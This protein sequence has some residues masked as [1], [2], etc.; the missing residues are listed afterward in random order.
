MKFRS[1]FRS[2]RYRASFLIAWLALSIF[3]LHMVISSEV[4]KAE[5]KFAH[6]VHELSTDI[7]QK[8]LANDAVLSGFSA[9]LQAVDESDQEATARYAAAA[10]APYPH[11]YML[12]VARQLPFSEQSSL[13][14]S[15][16]KNGQVNFSIRS[17]AAVSDQAII[18]EAPSTT[19][20]PILFIYPVIPVAPKI[21]G[22][23][24]ETVPFL[25]ESLRLI[26]HAGRAVASPIF[27]LSEGGGEAF[28]LLRQAER[29]S[30]TI[31]PGAPN[32]FGSSMAALL[33]S[34]STSLLP[35]DIGR[36]NI[37][38]HAE[39]L[40]EASTKAST[41][42]QQQTPTAHWLDNQTLPRFSQVIEPGISS[43]PVRLTFERQLSWAQLLGPAA[44]ATVGMLLA[45]IILVA[46]NIRRYHQA[47]DQAAAEHERAEHLAMHDELT[48]LPNR[49]LLNDRF[50][51][52]LH[53]WE[54]HGT[55]F[56]LFVIDLDH[57]KIIN[58]TQG[59]EAGDSVLVAT[60][61][62]ISQAIRAS[63]TV[64]RFGGDEFIVLIADVLNQ[65]D[66]LGLGQKL[67][68]L[69]NAPITWRN[70]AIQPTCSLGI[71][72]CPDDGENFNVL[73]QQADRA[74]YQVKEQGRNGAQLAI[75]L[76]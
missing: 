10:L 57:F 40:S 74:M 23:R 60:A 29:A 51:Q 11:I 73:F 26:Q 67:C 14:S 34:K 43:Q 63:D 56:A 16:K 70:K 28:I 27:K 1:A 30:A 61:N 58:D 3:G 64:A 37:G 19:I 36:K 72:L 68:S 31:K 53:R 76:A 32:L 46:V 62:R 8:L 12:E 55:K 33:V 4:K 21:Y 49:H 20:W 13:E 9:F 38:L 71:A 7:R 22:L 25:A 17:F 66:A 50:N 59:H 24:L 45:S 2:N 39:L 44:V 35:A 5:Q 47:I 52:N 42:F 54:R 41:L 18:S 69:I 65:A 48:G 6:D 75:N 15:I